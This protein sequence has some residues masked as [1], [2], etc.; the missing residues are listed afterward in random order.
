MENREKEITFKQLFDVFKHSLKWLIIF[1]MI[2]A[3]AVAMLVMFFAKPT[4]S[5]KSTYWVSNNSENQ[6]YLHSGQTGAMSSLVASCVELANQDKLVRAAVQKHSLAEKLGYEDEHACVSDVKKMISAE[7]NEN[8]TS[9]LFYVTV[10]SG[11]ARAVVEVT[12]ALRDVMPSVVRSLL[13][14]GANVNGETIT[15]VSDAIEVK[16]VRASKTSYITS[17]I[18]AGI[19]AAVVVYVIMLIRSILDTMV[20]SESNIKENF[21]HPILG[22]VPTW[23]NENSANPANKKKFK[24]LKYNKSGGVDVRLR[25]YSGRLLNSTTPFAI[26]EAFNA[27]RT[28]LVYSAVEGKNPI[29]AITG[30]ARAV[31]KSIISSNLAVSFTGLDKKVLLV[32]CDMRCP[33]LSHVFGKHVEFGLSDLIAGIKT[34]T[35]DV[36]TKCVNDNLDVI[37]A[38]KIPPNPSELLSSKRMER[39]IQEWREK[40]DCIILDMTPIGEVSD[41][42]VV[43]SVIDGYI[44]VARCDYSD[45]NV[46]K[47]AVSCIEKVNGKILGFVLNDNNPKNAG[48]YYK[49][50]NY[51]KSYYAITDDNK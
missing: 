11:D 45:V 34:N 31:G 49:K 43:A 6:D 42:G 47:N 32:E 9:F 41:A 12:N 22:T 30:E 2:A 25:D 18:Y 44:M 35:E 26:V 50:G 33:S 17:G 8:S 20:Y 23:D 5:H 16:D 14:I 21:D 46:I 28:N 19:G 29:I 1:G 39:L 3:I 4:Y 27:L 38:G 7:Y 10:K 48:Y 51:Y 15:A 36:V 40:Y 37:F 24:K 13:S